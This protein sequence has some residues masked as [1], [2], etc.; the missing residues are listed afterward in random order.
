[1]SGDPPPPGFSQ[2]FILKE[3]KVVCFHTL[4]QVLILKELTSHQNGAN[5]VCLARARKQLRPAG[6]RHRNQKRQQDA[7]V[8]GM[9]G[10]VVATGCGAQYYPPLML[11][12]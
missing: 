5:E 4:L 9:R 8:T 7:G 12:G 11:R 1:M 2:V 3:L 6:P 10:N